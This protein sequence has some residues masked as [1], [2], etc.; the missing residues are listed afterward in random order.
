MIE[1]KDDFQ[2]RRGHLKDMSDAELKKYFFEL[3]GKMIDPLI[4]LAR[5][6][7]S[8]SIERSILLRMGFSS[9]EAKGIVDALD[10][11]ELLPFG[12]GHAIYVL[13]KEKN[14][15]LKEAGVLLQQKDGMEFVKEYF[16]H[17]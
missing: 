15:P 17:E 1:R 14:I 6:N 4:D 11:E 5:E 16:N 3:A 8:K 10:D 7:T 2:E 9:I 12:A 13:A